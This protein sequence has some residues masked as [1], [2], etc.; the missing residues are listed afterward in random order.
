MCPD[1]V[2]LETLAGQLS[3]HLLPI[4]AQAFLS[5]VD[6]VEP[7]HPDAA[8]DG[9]S[10]DERDRRITDLIHHLTTQ[11]EGAPWLATSTLRTPPTHQALTDT[12]QSGIT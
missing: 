8:W 11:Q 10:T 6:Q 4:D 7:G 2:Y 12:G 3:W 5:H 1:V 9:H